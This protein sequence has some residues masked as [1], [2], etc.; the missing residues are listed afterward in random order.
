MSA[1]I[2]MIASFHMIADLFF[3]SDHSDCRVIFIILFTGLLCDNW[4]FLMYEPRK[5]QS[6]TLSC[7]NCVI[8]HLVLA[9]HS[10][11]SNLNV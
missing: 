11:N 5:G 2:T 3:L 6:P 8:L 7:A 10:N 4:N 9:F 1:M